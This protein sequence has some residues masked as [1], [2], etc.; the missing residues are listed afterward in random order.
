MVMSQDV[1]DRGEK[2]LNPELSV[3]KVLSKFCG[4]CSLGYICGYI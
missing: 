4:V 2:F 3:V 1:F